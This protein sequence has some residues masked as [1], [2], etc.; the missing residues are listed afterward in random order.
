M[1]MEAQVCADKAPAAEESVGAHG[2]TEMVTGSETLKDGVGKAGSHGDEADSHGDGVRMTAFG[3]SGKSY[4]DEDSRTSSESPMH[5]DSDGKA[6]SE[7]DLSKALGDLFN[8]ALGLQIRRP[9]AESERTRL[10]ERL[11]HKVQPELTKA[12]MENRVA[13][14]KEKFKNFELADLRELVGGGSEEEEEGSSSMVARGT[15][16][17]EER[18]LLDQLDEES[19]AELQEEVTAELREKLSELGLPTEG[20]LSEIRSAIHACILPL[21]GGIQESV[22]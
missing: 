1:E 11:I 13:A 6:P 21:L 16:R 17:E 20:S 9:S 19:F 18:T 4:G 8:K 22:F 14:L 10:L 2:D 3:S 5:G 15:L 7:D 12:E